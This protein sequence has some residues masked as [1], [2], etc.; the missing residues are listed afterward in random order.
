M[1]TI[2]RPD[3]SSV[4]GILSRRVSKPRQ[5]DMQEAYRVV[6]YLNHTKNKQLVLSSCDNLRPTGYT[7]ADW[8]GNVD[9][10]KSTSGFIFQLGQSTI[11]W[12]SK[13]QNCV[14][15]SSTEAEFV[16]ASY[17][18]QECTWLI[19]LLKDF[20]LNQKLPIILHEDNQSV[21]KLCTLNRV[22]TFTKH[23][24]VKFCYIKD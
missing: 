1:S 12:S 20:E 19:Q 18:S 8:A 21:I 4:V 5:R 10:R 17:A 23:I 13:K 16:A 2:T 3:I 22:S 11:S 7:D 6:R 14:A 9:D 24:D 15:L